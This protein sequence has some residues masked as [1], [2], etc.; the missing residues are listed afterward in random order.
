MIFLFLDTNLFLHY[1]GFEDIPWKNLL[2]TT[3]DITIV[4]VSIVLR[5][6]NGHKDS[7]KGRLKTGL[8]RYRRS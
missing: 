4:L 3:D 5:E 6:I 1:K 8:G 7:S 2:N